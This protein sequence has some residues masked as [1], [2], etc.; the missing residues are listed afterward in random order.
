M[1]F[2]RKNIQK[3]QGYAPGEQTS[4]A[5]IIKL[6]TNENP[7]PPSPQVAAA[8]KSIDVTALR[9]Y[10]SPMADS[11]REAASKLHKLS[12]EQIIPTNGGDELLRLVLTTYVEPLDT[13]AVCKP[14]YSLYP[15]LAEIQG[16]QLKEISLL[17]DW[18][19]PEDFL[20]Q[21]NKSAAKLLILVNP[22]APT[23]AL[24][25]ADYLAEIAE[26][27]SGLLLIDEAYVDFI[28]PE[29]NYDSI[30]LINSHDNILILR[31]LSKAY[32]LAGLRFGYGI[33][34]KSLIEPMM[35]KTRD[36]YNTDYIA[37]SLATAALNSIEYTRENCKRIRQSREKMR[38][39]LRELGLI[40]PVSQ[41][42]FILCQVPESI[43]AEK[44]YQQLK[45]R[46]ILVRYFDQDRLRDKLRISIGTEA[47]NAALV[48][49]VKEL[50]NL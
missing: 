12:A 37:Q 22:N 38:T 14:S 2:E 49:A 26:N 33:G 32:S 11:F 41:S 40:A 15:V 35:F 27:F 17:D 25:R 50:G 20:T 21:L 18:S 34:A 7:Y 19:M 4:T 24:L 28:D 9:R 16:C 47:E 30:S 29:L 36:S 42:N 39:D 3:M 5:D 48:A 45:Q 31:T 13:I 43:G 23:G 6:N 1:N 46:N 44:L 10:P 8:L